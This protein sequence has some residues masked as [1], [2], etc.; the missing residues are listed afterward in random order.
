MPVGPV[1]GQVSEVKAE[2]EVGATSRCGTDR[3]SLK[4]MLDRV[5]A[6]SASMQSGVPVP[7][8]PTPPDLVMLQGPQRI[9]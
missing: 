4:L 6:A 1:T 2:A 7:P 8:P 5:E 9:R 3:E